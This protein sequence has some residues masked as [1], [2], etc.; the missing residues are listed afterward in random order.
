MA[1][2]TIPGIKSVREAIVSEARDGLNEP[3]AQD[4]GDPNIAGRAA[5][6]FDRTVC[7]DVEA[8]RSVDAVQAATNV[9]NGRAVARQSVRLEVDVAELDD[10]LARRANEPFALPVDPRVA[11]GAFA[12]VPDG[13]LWI[14]SAF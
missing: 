5:P 8:A 10:A 4:L 6:D 3:D 7:A 9:S 1:F 13:E 11:D 14:H 12:I 2:A